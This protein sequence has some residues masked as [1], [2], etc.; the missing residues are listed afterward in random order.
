MVTFNSKRNHS[1]ASRLNWFF[2]R[3]CTIFL[4]LPKQDVTIPTLKMKK[5]V[6]IVGFLMILPTTIQAQKDTPYVYGPGGPF[7][8]INE[9]ALIFGKEHHVF[10]KVTAGPEDKWIE[11]AKQN[12]DLIFGGAAYMLTSFSMKHPGFIDHSSPTELYKRGVVILV[13]PGNPKKIKSI[14][15][16]TKKGITILDVNGAGQLGLWEDIAGKENAIEGIQKNIKQ[17]FPNMAL[18]IAAWKSAENFDAWI[19]YES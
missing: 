19:N 9:S 17:S 5:L 18:G 10:V 6:S 14:R 3:N 1:I 4:V 16:L 11:N 13:K 2:V 8:P 7:A 15:D 12:A